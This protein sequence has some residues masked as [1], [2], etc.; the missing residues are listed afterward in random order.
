[1]KPIAY[2][3]KDL[4]DMTLINDETK[5]VYEGKYIDMRI[6]MSTIPEGKYGYNCRHD[7]D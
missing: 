1:M 7:D 5:E 6:D 3:Q 2:N 4:F